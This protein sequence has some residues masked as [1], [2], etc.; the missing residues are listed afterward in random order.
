MNQS[1]S[2]RG[3]LRGLQLQKRKFAQPKLVRVIKGR[4]LKI[5]FKTK[6]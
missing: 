4:V 1:I 3:V 6:S 2:Q 5:L